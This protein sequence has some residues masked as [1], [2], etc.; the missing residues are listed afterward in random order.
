LITRLQHR[1]IL[2][3]L[4]DGERNARQAAIRAGYGKPGAAAVAC[5]LLQCEEIQNEIQRQLSKHCE[6]LKIDAQFVVKGILDSIETAKESGTGAWQSQAVLRGY[7]LLG[8]YLGIFTDK[9]AVDMDQQIMERL[10]EGGRYAAGIRDEEDED[11]EDG[12]E[13]TKPN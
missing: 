5:R 1:F 10:I 6:E 2:E 8:R 11:K 3:Y 13:K 12:A 9:V 4:A 7:E